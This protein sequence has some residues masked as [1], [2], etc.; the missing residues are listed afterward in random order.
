MFEFD[1]RL[2]EKYY[3]GTNASL[4]R[5]MNRKCDKTRGKPDF[6]KNVEDR[7]IIV[8]MLEQCTKSFLNG[9]TELLPLLEIEII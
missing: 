3:D 4:E 2:N 6:E 5:T 1:Y 9:E 8:E 7:N